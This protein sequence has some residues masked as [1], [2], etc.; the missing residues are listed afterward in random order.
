MVASQGF[1]RSWSASALSMLGTRTL[2]VIYP[3]LAMALTGSAA[4]AGWVVFA[5]MLP[6]LLCYLP[7]GTI[8]DRLGPRRVMLWS[9]ALRA[10]L[11]A[12]LC[13]TMLAGML[14]IEHL[15][16]VAFLEGGLAVVTS[17]AEAALVTTTARQARL[18]TA[19]AMHETTVHAIAL[20]GR[21]L[22]GAL[23]ALGPLTAFL[24]NAFFFAM[25]AGVLV[26]PPRAAPETGPG[27]ETGERRPMLRETVMGFREVWR[28][29]FIR[30]AT[31]L[32]ALI[33]LIVQSLTVVSI[34]H[35][36]GGG[37]NPAV[38]GTILSASG[39]GGIIGGLISPR[40][41][42]ISRKIHEKASRRMSAAIFAEWV[43]L[44]RHGRSMLL[45]HAWMC[46]LA[47]LLTAVTGIAPLAFA[48]ALL[49]I[50]LA[51]GLSNVT[52]RTVLSDVPHHMTARVVGVSRLVS[53]GVAALGP[54]LFT[55]FYERAGAG[56]TVGTLALAMVVVALSMTV[57]PPFRKSL[58]PNWATRKV[59]A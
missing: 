56:L 42:R 46:S 5:S 57:V 18:H 22:G 48:V 13:G 30:S 47:L 52:I 55:V 6:G 4:W 49:M 14:R 41:R 10:L 28:H 24:S 29:P 7:A 25:S 9:E 16:A 31:I 32:T 19:L 38:I 40:R 11:M 53:Y 20:A 45:V 27:P 26:R 44:T 54:P 34:S 50:G 1:V 8:S 39:V 35:M 36:T 17:V 15:L 58:S 2:S 33:N 12:L 37:L 3:L 43:G 21:P 51:G 59:T 23:Y